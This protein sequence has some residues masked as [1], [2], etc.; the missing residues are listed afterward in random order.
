MSIRLGVTM[1]AA[2]FLLGSASSLRA[3]GSASTVP[4]A[5]IASPGELA[6]TRYADLFRQAPIGHRQ[7]RPVDIPEATLATRGDDELRRLATEID[8]KLII[9]RGC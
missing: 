4:R 7:P 5:T 6:S 2:T 8:R 3:G 1:V 9:C